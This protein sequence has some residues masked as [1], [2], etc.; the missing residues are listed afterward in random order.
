M[1]ALI[2]QHRGRVVDSPGDNLLAEFASVVDAVQAAVAIQRELSARNVESSL[3]RRMEFRIGIS[4]G[5]VIVEGDRIYG[6][7]V[8]IAARME[9]LAEPAGICVSGTVY[10]QVEG[11][12][13]LAYVFEGEHTVKNIAKPVRVYRVYMESA[14]A[15]PRV[16]ASRMHTAQPRWRAALAPAVALLILAGG[17]T[18]WRFFVRSPLLVTALHSP[19]ATALP[20]PTKPS[21]AVLPFINLSQDP[22]Q[23]YFS[24][25]IT[26]DLINNL[27]RISG[28]FVIAR[29][30]TF[31]YKG[32]AVKTE[33]V[34][35]ELGVRYVLDGSV[36][37]ADGRVRITVR[38]VDATSGYHLWAERYDREVKSIFASQDEI[39][40]KIVPSLA[41][42]LKA[43]EEQ[44]METNYTD[45]QQAWDHYIR[46]RELF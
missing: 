44:S 16:S 37:K 33:Q 38:L 13:N 26:E 39:T 14:A 34:S 10:D 40:R 25:G 12:L 22:E 8:N 2:Q 15:G 11:K 17:V 29:Y 31:T 19:E 42:K 27:S 7:G 36:R 41:V 21:N 43:G 46:A 18:G 24:D 35:R 9:G 5:D 28:L 30:S 4:L 45:N 3:H 6:D 1:S 32:R 20:L 23:E